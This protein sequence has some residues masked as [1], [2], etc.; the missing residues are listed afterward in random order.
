MAEPLKNAF[1]PD[2]PRRLAETIVSVHPTFPAEAFL[3]D[4]LD[5]YAPL[6]LLDRGRQVA[7]ALARHLPQDF[8]TAADIVIASLGP[9]LERT[10][11]NGMAPFF[12]L[13]HTMFVSDNGIARFEAS[14]RALYELTQRFTAEMAIRPFIV[15][16][17]ERT[18]ARLRDWSGDPNVHVRR[19]VSEGTR[20]RLPWAMRLPAFQRDPA[21]VIA[22]LERLKDDPELYVRRSVANNLNDIGKDHPAILTDVA[23]KWLTKASPERAWIV[24]HALRSAIKRGEAAA[25]AVLDYAP[26]KQIRIAHAEIVPKRAKIGGKLTIA[27]DVTNAGKAPARLMV[28]FRIHYVKA[29]GST[30]PK[31]FKLSALDLAAGETV[32]LRKSVS[33]QEMTTRKH[34]PGEHRIDAVINGAV[35]PLGSFKLSR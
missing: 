21:P 30:S 28:D 34:Y 11:N 31:T 12:Y 19:L 17:T 33:L 9:K 16:D 20:P 7:R 10:E 14:M 24:R 22:L 5:G 3:V 23:A 35:T 29:K 15:K 13:P 26:V 2:V 18:L 1:G 25:L 27:F 8:E 32:S 6:A 4:A